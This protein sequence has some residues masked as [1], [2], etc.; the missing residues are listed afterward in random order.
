MTKHERRFD[1]LTK[2]LGRHA[3]RRTVFKAV[4]AATLGSVLPRFAARDE[5]ADAAG[6]IRPACLRTGQSCSLH[7]NPA[8]TPCCSGVCDPV[9][10]QC[11]L[12]QNSSCLDDP[13]CVSGTVC[14][15]NPAGLG[16]RCLP[17][18]GLGAKCAEHDDC[19]SGFCDPYTHTCTNHCTGNTGACSANAQC[20]SGICDALSHTCIAHLLPLGAACAANEDC[21]TGI[22]RGG[23]CQVAGVAGQVC[24]ENADC[25]SGYLCAGAGPSCCAALGTTCVSNGDCCNNRFCVDLGGGATCIDSSPPNLADDS[26]STPRNT[27]LTVAAPGVLGNDGGV[28][29]AVTAYDAT[30]TLSG[31]V[32]MQP[33]G[34]FVYTPPS[35]VNS[36][37]DDTFTYTVTNAAGT[38]S[39]TV[40]IR[41]V[42][43]PVAADDPSYQTPFNTAL[44][45]DAPGVL[46]NDTINFATIGAYDATSVGGGAVALH[47]DGS[48]S[49]T[50]ASGYTGFDTFTYTL[51]NIAG[52]DS[53][54]VTVQVGIAPDAVDDSYTA[55]KN[56]VLTCAGA[57]R[58]GQRHRQRGRRSAATWARPA[59]VARSA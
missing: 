25:A 38:D 5:A 12:T 24:D 18:G 2:V 32:V 55:G 15:P 9:T 16:A 3:S 46:G 14:R 1:D 56:T 41:I 39:A 19:A 20:C 11:R 59:R 43:P 57:R 22:C 47:A 28:P 30:T 51:T 35:N 26:Y 40:T 6:N 21:A 49:Y 31:T 23:T 10:Q 17:P 54:T 53:A 13:D 58:A 36:L 42:A 45:V 8:H 48:F 29:L 37:P 7:D 34:S 27:V 50:P 52:S 4:I 33:N 44:T